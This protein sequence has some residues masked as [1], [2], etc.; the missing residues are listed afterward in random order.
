VSGLWR[1]D[2]LLRTDLVAVLLVP[3]LSCFFLPCGLSGVCFA[4]SSEADECCLRALA[5]APP[6]TF[7][8]HQFSWVSLLRQYRV[9]TP[10]ITLTVADYTG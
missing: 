9:H 10:A 7:A 5:C 6:V 2:R 1:V 8:T 3:R 4:G